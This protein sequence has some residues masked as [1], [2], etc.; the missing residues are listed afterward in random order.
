MGEIKRL[1][2]VCGKVAEHACSICG[3]IVCSKHYDA[4]HRVC[5]DH[6]KTFG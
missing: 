1:C 2:S 6:A 5:I 4:K 3:K